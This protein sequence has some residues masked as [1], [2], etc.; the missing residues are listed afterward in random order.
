MHVPQIRAAWKAVVIVRCS[1]QDDACI[2]DSTP[3][4]TAATTAVS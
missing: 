4:I 1:F 3:L 2:H